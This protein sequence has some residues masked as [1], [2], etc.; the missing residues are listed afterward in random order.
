MLNLDTVTI[1]DPGTR[2]TLTMPLNS[3]V[4]AFVSYDPVNATYESISVPLPNYW[5]PNAN[6]DI[7]LSYYFSGSPPTSYSFGAIPIFQKQTLIC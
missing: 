6:L 5:S 7:S 2:I 1:I 4:S 3:S